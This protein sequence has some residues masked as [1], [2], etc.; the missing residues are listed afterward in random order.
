MV[1]DR[2]RGSQMR[3][4]TRIGGSRLSHALDLR[5][6]P[7]DSGFAPLPSNERAITLVQGFVDGIE[8][9]ALLRGPSGWGKSHLL[10][11][12][13]LALA[14][15]Y[16]RRIEP[17]SVLTWVRSPIKPEDPTPLILDDFAEILGSL[18]FRH[19]LRHRLER[20]KK[21]G[22]ATLVAQTSESGPLLN[23]HFGN[24]WVTSVIQSPSAEERTLIV[25]EMA[26]REGMTLNPAVSR[27]IARR[28]HGNGRS[29]L[30]ALRRLHLDGANWASADSACRAGGVLMPYFLG[31]DGWDPRDQALE[32]VQSVVGDRPEA[33]ALCAF[34][35]LDLMGHSEDETAAFLNMPAPKVY[36]LKQT[37][38]KADEH[39]EEARL[40]KACRRAVIESF[41][42]L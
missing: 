28:I 25:Q 29:I 26:I 16:G 6:H 20:R 22:R 36:Q 19:E 33:S 42:K 37:I 34:C 23:A 5:S 21:A 14:A 27:L 41:V 18:R 32:A 38:A 31:D 35:L 24:G 10:S 15:R 30:G 2:L 3:S 40:A 4:D 9:C 1:Q 8:R 7:I 12:A 13:A 17:V 39:S 11:N